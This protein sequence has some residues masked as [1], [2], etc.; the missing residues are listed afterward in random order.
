MTFNEDDYAIICKEI[1]KNDGQIAVYEIEVEITSSLLNCLKLRSRFNPELKYF[2]LKRDN[3]DLV[4]NA[5]K[6]KNE[7]SIPNLISKLVVQL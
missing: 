4:M 2:V 1:S 5:L 7:K 6:H 3:M